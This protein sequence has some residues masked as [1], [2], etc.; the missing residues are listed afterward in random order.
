V[1]PTRA[2]ASL[3]TGI[4]VVC[5]LAWPLPT[6][7]SPDQGA[8]FAQAKKRLPQK[9]APKGVPKQ[10]ELPARTPFTLEDQ[11]AAKVPGIP[12][13]RAW[14]DSATDF[15][16]LLP[17]A[18]GPWLALSGGGADGAYGA[19]VITG[20]SQTGNRPEFTLVS[21]VSIGAL[22]APYAF[23]G[24]RYDED[25]RQNFLSI[26]AAD[27]FE[28]HATPESLMDTWPLKR[29]IEKRVSA[30]MLTEIAA[31]HRRGRRLLV[32]TTNLDAGRRVIWNMG[33][34]AERGDD[35]ALKLFRDILL[36]S[37]SIPGFFPP[38]AIEV[39]ANGKTFQEMHLDG[40]VTAPFFVAP[41]SMFEPGAAKL[42]A[43][44]L[45]VIVNSKLTPA[46]DMPERKTVSVLGRTIG[47]AL[48]AG[49]RSEVLLTV[50]GA[51]RL[52]INLDVAHVPDTFQVPARSLFDQNYMQALFD[53]GAEQAKKGA[54]FERHPAATPELRTKAAQ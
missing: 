15:A 1:H 5:A 41:E 48:T 9:A 11:L 25:L 3:A 44:Q 45:Y 33:A 27:V 50:V 38:V 19:G 6:P 52:G 22:I 29:L 40:T 16:R 53:L 47:V 12:D 18:S 24:S 7:F 4:I 42:P 36:A 23:L 43:N 30:K 35:K 32:A 2:V 31:E 39:E 54:A 21:G 46:F 26:T 8:A 51:Q 20:W 28:D 49:L 14:G 13:A 10:P 17:S 37:S 34:I